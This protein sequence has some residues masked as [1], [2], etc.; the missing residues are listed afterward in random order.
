MG[1]RGKGG[2]N[3]IEFFFALEDEHPI[4]QNIS[5]NMPSGSMVLICFNS[6]MRLNRCKSSKIMKSFFPGKI[7]FSDRF[8]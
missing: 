5:R 3:E 6:K 4:L 1:K 2:G 7:R 8:C